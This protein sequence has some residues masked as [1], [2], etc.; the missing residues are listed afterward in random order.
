MCVAGMD[1]DMGPRWLGSAAR[2]WGATLKKN[3]L[4]GN[5]LIQLNR[6]FQAQ[7]YI[8]LSMC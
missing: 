1:K 8:Y 3:I 4:V 5:L 2:G 7:L 6:C